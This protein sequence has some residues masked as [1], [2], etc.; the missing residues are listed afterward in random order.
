MENKTNNLLKNDKYKIKV[1][2][3]LRD[4]KLHLN[5]SKKIFNFKIYLYK[6]KHPGRM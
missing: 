2:P 5:K 3:T 6:N 4:A 1:A